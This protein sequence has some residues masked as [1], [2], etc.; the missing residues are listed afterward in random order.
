M[1]NFENCEL[2][3]IKRKRDLYYRLRVTEENV[4]LILNKYKVYINEKN[5][6]LECQRITNC[7][8]L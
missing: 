6:I 7:F 4:A 2:Y 8:K 5:R 1:I 3:K